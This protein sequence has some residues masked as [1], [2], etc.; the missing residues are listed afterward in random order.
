M[1]LKEA[2]EAL[3]E[4]DK[5]ENPTP[6]TFDE[7]MQMD[8]EPVWTVLTVKT[9]GQKAGYALIY[10]NCKYAT[11]RWENSPLWYSEYGKTWIAYPYKPKGETERKEKQNT[12]TSN[13]CI[14]CNGNADYTISD[15]YE[16][17]IHPKMIGYCWGCGRK[18]DDG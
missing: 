12:I 2:A 18:L 17:R 5:Q 13:K 4:L 14:W 15:K 6:L 8:G 11:Q 7:I 1:K 16:N 3:R 10:N 9:V